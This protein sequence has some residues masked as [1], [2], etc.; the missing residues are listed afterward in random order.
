MILK[1]KS[2]L[3]TFLHLYHLGGLLLPT[4]SVILS[5][6]NGA[7]YEVAVCPTADSSPAAPTP[8]LG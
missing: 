5:R 7:R 1:H 3:V 6:A 2:D 8:C 4:K